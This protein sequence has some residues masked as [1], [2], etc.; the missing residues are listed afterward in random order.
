MNSDFPRIISLLRKER[1]ISQKKAAADLGISQ[2]LLSHYEKGIRECGLEFLVKAADYYNVSCDYLLGRSPEPAG[3]TLSYD[4]I[5]E[6]DASGNRVA[7]GGMMAAFN[8]KLIVNST[9]V[10][11]SLIQKTGSNTIM[12]EASS[13]LMLAI[14]KMFRVVYAANPKND[15]RFFTVPEITAS[16]VSSAAM[17]V[18]ESNALAAAK[19]IVIG[20][21][22]TAVETDDTLITTGAL[23]EEYAGSASSLLNTIKNSEARIQMLSN[24]QQK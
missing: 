14:Y 15:Q 1:G 7:A 4:D 5:P 3:K 12:K 24:P 23:S 13:Y 21:G 2:A 6:Q 10:L 18:C 8:K 17:S 16:G 11:F 9:N 19:G 20:D 22:D